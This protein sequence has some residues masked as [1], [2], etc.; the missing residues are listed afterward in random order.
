MPPSNPLSF[1][2]PA[3]NITYIPKGIFSPRSFDPL[4]ASLSQNYSQEYSCEAWLS[5]LCL[6]ASRGL[7]EVVSFLE[8]FK[9]TDKQRDLDFALFLANRSG[10]L[11]TAALLLKKANPARKS[12]TNG[13]HGAA[14]RGLN[15]QICDYIGDLNADPDV[16][17]GSSATP[18]IYAMLGAQDEEGAWETIE[19]LFNLGASPWTTFGSQNLSYS[20]IARRE[21]KMV[22]AQKLK[23]WETCP[24]PTILNSSRESSSMPEG[25]NDVL[26]DDER[27]QECSEA[28]G[29]ANSGRE[30][31]HTVVEGDDVQPDNER[32]REVPEAAGV[33]PS[34]E[35]SCTVGGADVIQPEQPRE[36]LEADGG[37]DLSRKTSHSVG[38]DNDQPNNKRPREDPEVDGRAKRARGA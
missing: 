27:P 18:V 15:E 30:A 2:F 6:A 3:G 4:R 11:E 29:G 26:P 34:R 25:D 14:W 35:S 20:E 8:G 32:P 23:E 31:S 10:H 13:L 7:T 12:S 24:S 38:G 5:P 37:A 22:L 19:C 28:T 21:R 36:G 1:G 17:D 16:F 9:Y 33:Y